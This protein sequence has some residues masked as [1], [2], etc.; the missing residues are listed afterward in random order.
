MKW[1]EN[2]RFTIH[3]QMKRQMINKHMT[4]AVFMGSNKLRNVK[5]NP[6]STLTGGVCLF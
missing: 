5:K 3:L 6:A 2:A 1:Q 4:A